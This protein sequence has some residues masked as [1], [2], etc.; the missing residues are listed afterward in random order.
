MNSNINCALYKYLIIIGNCFFLFAFGKVVYIL[1]HLFCIISSILYFFI[2]VVFF[3][4]FY[5]ISF[6]LYYFIYFILFHFIL[7]SFILYYFICIKLFHQYYIDSI[8]IILFHF[9][10]F[11]FWNFSHCDF[12]VKCITDLQIPLEIASKNKHQLHVQT[13]IRIFI[14]VNVQVLVCEGSRSCKI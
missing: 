6:T 1:F 11:P 14:L 13:G 3:H 7:F 9:Y 8:Y 10:Y 4:L 5:I 2:Y 12:D